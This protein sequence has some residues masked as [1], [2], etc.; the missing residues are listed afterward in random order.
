MKRFVVP[1]LLLFLFVFE[2]LFTQLFPVDIFNGQYIFVPRFLIIAIF[3]LTIYGNV[4]HGIIYG[5]LFGLLFDM[6]YTE[7]IGVYF[8]LFPLSA[9]LFLKIM[10][11]V[12]TNI[13]LVSFVSL[14]CVAFLEAGVYML[15]LLIQIT[16][17]DFSKFTQIR[18]VPTLAMNLIFVLFVA[19][20]FKRQF[21]KF[22]DALRND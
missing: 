2:G 8:F 21:E 17:M 15:N 13:F 4:K 3:F 18:L 20:P 14:M 1:V 10:K 12:Q 7:V 16:S 22:A 5:F 6:V 9:Y 11:I 19:Y